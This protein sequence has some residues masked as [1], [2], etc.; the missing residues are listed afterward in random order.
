MAKLAL[1]DLTSTVSGSLITTT[2]N[3]NSLLETALE[4]T[5]SRDGTNPNEMNAN[6]D[7][8]SNRIY[9]L[10]E[11]TSDTEP[12]RY[13]EFQPFVDL[14]NTLNEPATSI[15][16]I[17]D[18]GG[19]ALSPGFKGYLEIPFD[20]GITQ[21]VALADQTG[22]IIVDIWK[23]TYDNFPPVDAN[24]ITAGA[25]VTLAAARKSK[26]TTLSGWITQIT[27]GDILG[28]NVD[29]SSTLTRVTLSLTATKT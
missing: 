15:T 25:P 22:N 23:T 17:F 4:N 16:F 28:F 12:V 19:V 29:S 2:N 6:L 10:P 20:C 11:A 5:L 24:S 13:A 8:N 18:G 21:A 1:G 7:M 27:A 26:D 3:N 14:F 9:N